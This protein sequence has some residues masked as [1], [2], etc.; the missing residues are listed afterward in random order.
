[1]Y[2][3]SW[4]KRNS[5]SLILTFFTYTHSPN[6][7]PHLSHLLLV[8]DAIPLNIFHLIVVLQL[9]SL[10]IKSPVFQWLLHSLLRV[11]KT[12]ILPNLRSYGYLPHLLTYRLRY[13]CIHV[14]ALGQFGCYQHRSEWKDLWCSSTVRLLS[15]WIWMKAR[16]CGALVQFGCYQ[17]RHK[18]MK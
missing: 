15:A 11:I 7:V 1:M 16:V 14:H 9:W 4:C 2:Y 8:V 6:S 17:H 13:I 18:W 3:L 10:I 5:C 12:A